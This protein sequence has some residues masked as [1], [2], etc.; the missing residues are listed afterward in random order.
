[1]TGLT[2]VERIVATLE[3]VAVGLSGGV[4]SSL[5]AAVCHRVLGDRAVAV[6]AR[7]PSLPTREL[8]GAAAVAQRIGIDLEVVDTAEV[9]D[10]RYA[11]NA[12]D[13]CGVCK[14]HQ[15]AALRRIADERGLPHIAHGE[16]VDD[17]G[18][19]RPGRAAAERWGARAPLRE[20]GLGKDAVRLAARALGLP[21]W[22]KPAFACLASRIP[23]GTEV[24]PERLTRIEAAEQYLFDLGL[25]AFR[26][27]HDGPT[28]RLELDPADHPR[29]LERAPEV[30]ARFRQL[31]FEHVALDLAGLAPSRRRPL[32]PV[33]GGVP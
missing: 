4:D 9:A 29:V 2:E 15:F 18:E 13:R 1:V 7:S 12:R 32:L 11:G 30:V 33:V 14:D 3:G 5:L 31:G 20:A 21:V 16:T 10:P 23:Y 28:A 8:D 24:T 25:R 22:D 17:L 27:R 19:H 6:V 26:V